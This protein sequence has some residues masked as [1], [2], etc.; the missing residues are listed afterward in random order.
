M[1]LEQLRTIGAIVATLF[2]GG[3][4]VWWLIIVADRIGVKPQIVN[5]SVVL[6]EWGRAKDILLV[7]LPLFSAALAVWVG[8]QGTSEAKKDAE[9]A[10]QQLE[11]VLD[12]SKEPGILAAAR[13][14]HPDAFKPK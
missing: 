10:K 9:G 6:D 3:I 2:T 14:K 12:T 8:S 4:L 11:A 5:G 1:T 7:I 13:E